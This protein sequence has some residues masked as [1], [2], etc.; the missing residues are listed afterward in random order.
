MVIGMGGRRIKEISTMSR[1]E[2]EVATGRKIFLELFV[3][4][5]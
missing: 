4:E 2:L 5:E 1:K 3:E